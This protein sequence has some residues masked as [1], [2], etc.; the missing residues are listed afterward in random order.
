MGDSRTPLRNLGV[1]LGCLLRIRFCM[2]TR[3][4]SREGGIPGASLFLATASRAKKGLCQ[5]GVVGWAGRGKAAAT[6][7][8]QERRLRKRCAARGYAPTQP[9]LE[10][11]QQPGCCFEIVCPPSCSAGQSG[12]TLP[13]LGGMQDAETDRLLQ[14]E[15]PQPWR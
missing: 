3:P 9:S 1:D 12:E 2:G 15:R 5:V 14:L 7:L 4:W 6:A 10:G 13:A 11:G 8:A